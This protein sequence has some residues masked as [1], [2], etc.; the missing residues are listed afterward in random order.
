MTILVTDCCFLAWL[1]A[2]ESQPRDLNEGKGSTSV[3][4]GDKHVGI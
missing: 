1:A 3:E 2:S 4:I